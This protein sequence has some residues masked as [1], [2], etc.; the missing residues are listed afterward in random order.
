M[1]ILPNPEFPPRNVSAGVKMP[2][3]RLPP[4]FFTRISPNHNEALT[5]TR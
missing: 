4:E 2:G 1:L 5:I 3:F